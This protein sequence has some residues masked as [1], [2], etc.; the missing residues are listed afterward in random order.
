MKTNTFQKSGYNL[1]SNPWYADGCRN[2][3]GERS[4]VARGSRLS[5]EKK[6][7]QRRECRRE[8]MY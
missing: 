2:G 8:E 7:T 1:V 6:T 4:E 3:E 5:E